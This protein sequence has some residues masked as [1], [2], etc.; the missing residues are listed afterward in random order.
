MALLLRVA[1]CHRRP[2]LPIGL[3][4]DGLRKLRYTRSLRPIDGRRRAPWPGTGSVPPP[5]PRKNPCGLR[6]KLELARIFVLA[7]PAKLT[8]IG[9]G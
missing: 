6:K 4:C 5:H 2:K 1:H 9:E 3:I 7:I 8:R